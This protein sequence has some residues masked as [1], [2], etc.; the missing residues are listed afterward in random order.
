MCSTTGGD[1]D[2]CCDNEDANCC[3]AGSKATQF[4]LQPAVWQTSAILDAASKRYN[5][6]SRSFS[7]S[8]TPTTTTS[9][10]TTTTT[11]GISSTPTPNPAQNSSPGSINNNNQ[12][13]PTSNT[14]A[15]SNELSPGAKA[16]I[17]VG[18]A[19]GAVLLAVLA[20]MAGRM[21]RMQR[22]IEASNQ[23]RGAPVFA[24]G[25]DDGGEGLCGQQQQRDATPVSPYLVKS[26]ELPAVAEA[27]E[28]Y[29]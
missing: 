9:S 4:Q 10:T 12:P 25:G 1:T 2:Y 18:A 23:W 6:V 29:G 11:T 19:A 3:D 14:A 21:R 8:S 28:V 22:V 17:G 7:P 15:D 16:G 20:Y 13:A 26:A 24:S 27:A 5:L